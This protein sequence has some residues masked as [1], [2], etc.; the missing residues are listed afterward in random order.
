ME[1]DRHPSPQSGGC[2]RRPKLAGRKVACFVFKIDHF[3]CFEGFQNI[4]SSTLIFTEKSFLL[5]KSI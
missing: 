5:A 4:Q 1:R 2:E 3:V